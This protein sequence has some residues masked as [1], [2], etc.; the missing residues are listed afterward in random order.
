MARNALRS[1]KSSAVRA[2]IDRVED[3]GVAVLLVGDGRT[4]VDV[5]RDLLPEGAREGD[6]LRIKFS[7]DAPARAGA[8]DRIAKLQEDLEARGNTASKKDF[9]V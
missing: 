4:Q 1:E 5:P 6:H 7:L 3:G 8:E 9:N 2:V